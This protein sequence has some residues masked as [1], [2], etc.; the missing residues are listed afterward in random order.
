M[1]LDRRNRGHGHAQ[2]CIAARDI[3]VFGRWSELELDHEYDKKATRQR[4]R[5][6][7]RVQ[8]A[9]QSCAQTRDVTS[10][11]LLDTMFTSAIE[12]VRERRCYSR[13]ISHACH[14]RLPVPGCMVLDHDLYAPPP[15][16]WTPY[17]D[18]QKPHQAA[19]WFTLTLSVSLSVLTFSITLKVLN[20]GGFGNSG[21]VAK[22]DMRRTCR[23]QHITS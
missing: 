4:A 6:S 15:G 16:I 11:A 12:I 7:L 8:E 2:G 18:V 21:S 13:R 17:S 1:K 5:P 23:A 19:G 20:G 22:Q 9:F 14:L 3:V 10:V